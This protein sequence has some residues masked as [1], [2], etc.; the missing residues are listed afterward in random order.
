MKS[1]RVQIP[2]LDGLA[3]GCG[4]NVSGA[5]TLRQGTQ[6]DKQTVNKQPILHNSFKQKPR[7]KDACLPALHYRAC[8]S[9]QESG[10]KMP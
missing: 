7:L 2:H 6:A 5:Q 10:L 3:V 9:N 1:V 4:Q 8:F